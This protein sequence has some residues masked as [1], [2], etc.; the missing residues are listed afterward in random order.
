MFINTAA[1]D[2]V[3]VWEHVSSGYEDDYLQK[4]KYDSATGKIYLT[5]GVTETYVAN[6]ALGAFLFTGDAETNLKLSV[7]QN[8]AHTEYTITA[9]MEWGSF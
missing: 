8:S 9:T 2:A 4:L 5:D 7:S 3:P 6:A 1:D